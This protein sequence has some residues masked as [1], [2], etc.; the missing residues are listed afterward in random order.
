M[1]DSLGKNLSN[2]I[3]RIVTGTSVDEK[4]VEEV[5]QDLRKIL[6]QADVDIKLTDELI[7]S[8]RKK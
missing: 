5:L 4:V 3:K 7:S 6:L 2:L 1:F 8:I